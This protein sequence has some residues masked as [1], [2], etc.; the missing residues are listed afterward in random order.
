MWKFRILDKVEAN[1]NL[2]TEKET[3]KTAKHIIYALNA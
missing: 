1:H 2:G 3:T